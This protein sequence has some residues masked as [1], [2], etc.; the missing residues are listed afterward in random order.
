MIRFTTGY[1]L[2]VNLAFIATLFALWALTDEV[3][4]AITTH[5]DI[6]RNYESYS[7]LIAGAL[8]VIVLAPLL[9]YLTGSFL[10]TLATFCYLNITLRT[11][12]SFV[13]A[14]SVAFLFSGD[15]KGKW[16]PLDELTDLPK[17]KRRDYLFTFADRVSQLRDF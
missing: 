17:E 2:I 3:V 6:L 14:R 11:R 13:E 9:A 4:S 1:H 12:V 7:F 15:S 16:Y 8:T 10:H 5:F